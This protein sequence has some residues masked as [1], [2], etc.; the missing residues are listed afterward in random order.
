MTLRSFRGVPVR[1]FETFYLPKKLV[2]FRGV[3]VKKNTLYENFGTSGSKK[4]RFVSEIWPFEV[5]IA[6]RPNFT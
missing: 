6:V 3:P 5:G 4:S 2:I 1:K